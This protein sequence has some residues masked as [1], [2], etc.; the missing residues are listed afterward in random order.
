VDRTILAAAKKQ[1][2]FKSPSQ[3]LV[4][5]DDVQTCAPVTEMSLILTTIAPSGVITVPVIK[6]RERGHARSD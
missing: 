1:P 2:R 6:T 4:I 5:A 3:S